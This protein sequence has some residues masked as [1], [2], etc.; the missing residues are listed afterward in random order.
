MY[1]RFVL[2]FWDDLI[3][4]CTLIYGCM[5]F[6]CFTCLAFLLS[7]ALVYK[8]IKVVYRYPVVLFFFG[9]DESLY[10]THNIRGKR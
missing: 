4:I 1:A 10:Y 2:G 9:S 8:Y 6:L 7:N 5:C 3:D